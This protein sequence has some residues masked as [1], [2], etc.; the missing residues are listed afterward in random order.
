MSRGTLQT[1][2]WDPADYT[3][4]SSAQL[5]WAREQIAR[6]D[7]HGDERIL[8]VGCG[9]GRITAEL[10]SRVP[11]GMV[12]GVDSSPAMLA[13]ARDAF[14][15]RTHPNLEFRAMDARQL[16]AGLPFDLIF[17]NAVLHWVDDHPAFVRAAAGCLRSGGR[18]VASCGGK[19][20]AREVFAVLRATMRMKR[21]RPFFRRVQAPYFFHSPEEYERW[22]PRYGFRSL[23]VRLVP[24]D[25]PFDRESLAAWLRT[26]WLPY[27]QR[28]PATAR[29][30]FVTEVVNR[31]LTRHYPDAA[32]QVFVRMVR[33]ELEAQKL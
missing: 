8:D 11:R 25:T 24:R 28:V 4:N 7:L 15:T 5:A 33:L 1:V 6:L 16:H 26:T 27:T 31:Y 32:G 14:P 12:V 2:E 29:R 9:D 17:S 19:G 23:Q 21:W 22:F 20:N 10:A 3:A 13:F 30:E 18:L